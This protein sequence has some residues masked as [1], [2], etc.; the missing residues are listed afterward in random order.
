M[1]LA[2]TM[3]MQVKFMGMIRGGTEHDQINAYNLFNRCL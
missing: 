3:D 2:L 1:T